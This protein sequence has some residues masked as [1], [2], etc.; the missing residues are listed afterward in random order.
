MTIESSAVMN[1]SLTVKSTFSSLNL[2]RTTIPQKSDVRSNEHSELE[3][4][5]HL[6]SNES[7]EAAP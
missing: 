3:K 2:W 7:L 5:D 6:K 4:D 1:N